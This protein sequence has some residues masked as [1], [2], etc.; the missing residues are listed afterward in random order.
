MRSKPVRILLKMLTLALLIGATMS[1]GSFETKTD[2]C[3]ICV[4]L[5]PG[6]AITRGCE[7]VQTG[8]L[9]CT[10]INGNACL[11]TGTWCSGPPLGE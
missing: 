9:G 4:T 7:V 10:P 2:A 5:D 6:S 1:V 8:D 3:A 11:L